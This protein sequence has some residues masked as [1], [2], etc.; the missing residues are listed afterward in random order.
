MYVIIFMWSLIK[1]IDLKGK[2][3][4]KVM[5]LAKLLNSDTWQQQFGNGEVIFKA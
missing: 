1:R 2:L 3:L 5:R 4:S